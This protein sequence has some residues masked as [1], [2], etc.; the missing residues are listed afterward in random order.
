MKTR[1]P[2]LFLFLALVYFIM[3]RIKLGNKRMIEIVVD[4]I[5]M[6]S[7]GDYLIFSGTEIY[8]LNINSYLTDPIRDL[9]IGVGS[10]IRIFVVGTGIKVFRSYPEI[11]RIERL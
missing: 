2:I 1:D 4:N 5:Q 10:N 3:Y 6:L 9:C 11:K 7:S 8:Y